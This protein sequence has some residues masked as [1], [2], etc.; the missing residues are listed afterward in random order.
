[1][2]QEARCMVHSPVAFKWTSRALIIFKFYRT[3]LKW[4][5]GIWWK[6]MNWIHLAQDRNQW[7]IFM[8]TDEAAPFVNGGKVVGIVGPGNQPG[9]IML[10]VGNLAD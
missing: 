4:L 7:Q 3:G 9:C 8:N 1:M 6:G 10:R 2:M 5:L